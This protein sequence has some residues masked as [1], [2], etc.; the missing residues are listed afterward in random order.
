MHRRIASRT[1]VVLGTLAFVLAPAVAKPAAFAATSSPTAFV[2]A[3]TPTTVRNDF[4][5]A[6]GMRFTV[7]TADISAVTLGR[8]VLS[9][10]A[11]THTVSLLD[12]TGTVLGTAP[13]ATAGVAADTFAYGSLP[14]PV[15]LRAGASYFVLSSESAGGDTWYDYGTVPV[16]TAAG[17]VSAAAYAAGAG[18]PV[19]GAG[20]T[21]AYGPVNLQYT[22]G[23]T[24]SSTTST[25]ANPTTTTTVKATTTTTISPTT[26]TTGAPLAP[27]TRLDERSIRNALG[28][29]G[30]IVLPAGTVKITKPLRITKSGTRLIG[31][32]R[33]ATVLR[34]AFGPT[35]YGPLL[36]LPAEWS[37]DFGGGN[38]PPASMRVSNVEIANLSID[39]AREGNPNTYGAAQATT[40]R[41]GIQSTISTNTYLHNLHIYDIAGD[42]IAFGDGTGVNVNPR[43]EDVLIERAGRNGVHLGSS[44]GAVI[45]RIQA[46]DTPGPYWAGAGA[47]NGLDIEV[48]GSQPEV[49]NT[50]IEN[51]VFERPSNPGYAGFG[52]QVTR[53]FGPVDNVTIRGNEFKNH[54]QGVIVSSASNVV[55]ENNTFNSSPMGVNN[56]TGGGI[57]LISAGTQYGSSAIV[58]FN[59]FNFDDWQWNADSIINV[60][61]PGNWAVQDNVMY[62]G[63]QVFK[64]YG[65]DPSAI[66]S[67]RNQ[68][69]PLN[70][71]PLFVAAT[72]SIQTF[73]DTGS[74]R[75]P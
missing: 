62:G 14:S 49:L 69:R 74:T 7:G 47:G 35:G 19:V 13:V 11:A 55:I 10:N 2:T 42:A 57:G 32:G 56:V 25:T 68:Y 45:N 46:L 3:F 16:T 23:S 43:V 66:V 40:L 36:A 48:E 24:A 9:G 31:A 71:G 34:M 64:A 39:G 50:L 67:A 1:A 72:P 27:N 63:V 17:Q 53:A 26:T 41:F 30:L 21:Q 59:Q 61:G 52:I 38:P 18:V 75:M 51:S 8:A 12:A 70:D 5:G 73:T 28:H 4:T 44:D 29:G 6:V 22:A 37:T 60:D 58:R 15:V 54:Q 33:D 20:A 65:P